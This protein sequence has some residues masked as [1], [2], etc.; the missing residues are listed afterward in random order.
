M[1][2]L[3]SC[4]FF[5]NFYKKRKSDFINVSFVF[6]ISVLFSAFPTR[7]LATHPDSPHSHPY[8]L[9]S[10]TPIPHISTPN[11]RIST[12]ICCIPTR[13]PTF[14]GFPPLFSAFLSFRSPIT[15]QILQ[16]ALKVGSLL[17]PF[18]LSFFL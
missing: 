14:P 13:F 10:Y 3:I 16:L 17:P 15:I 1:T 6:P 5:F 8:F 11:A 18:F 7:F 4:F 2:I 9:H 12:R